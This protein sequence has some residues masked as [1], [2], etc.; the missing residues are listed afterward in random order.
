[1]E[2]KPSTEPERLTIGDEVVYCKRHWA[3]KKGEVHII[4]EITRTQGTIQYATNRGAWFTREEFK[5]LRPFSKKSLT[6]LAE[7]DDDDVEEIDDDEC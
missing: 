2:A 3:W 1:M 7:M 6:E 4:S 5:F